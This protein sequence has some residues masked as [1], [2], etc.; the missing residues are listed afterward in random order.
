ML[1]AEWFNMKVTLADWQTVSSLNDGDEELQLYHL[2]SNC[3][4]VHPNLAFNITDELRTCPNP[5]ISPRHFLHLWQLC[6]GTAAKNSLPQLLRISVLRGTFCV[7]LLGLPLGDKRCL[8][9]K[10]TLATT[11]TQ[12]QCVQPQHHSANYTIFHTKLPP[13]ADQQIWILKVA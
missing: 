13:A 1:L 11:N 4:T 2:T 12:D 5:L 9:L 6:T 3:S 7:F 8:P 10:T